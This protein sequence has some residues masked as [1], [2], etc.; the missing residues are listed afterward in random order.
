[1]LRNR[2]G[3]ITVPT[4]SESGSTRPCGRHQITLAVAKNVSVGSPALSVSA[5]RSFD[6][7]PAFGQCCFGLGQ[8]PLLDGHVVDAFEEQDQVVPTLA[9]RARCVDDIKGD[10]V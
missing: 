8:W 1:M 4:A 5:T 9:V 10:P 7:G 2:L 6:H 3:R